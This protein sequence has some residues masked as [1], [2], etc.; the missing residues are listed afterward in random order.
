MRI[1]GKRLM[2]ANLLQGIVSVVVGLNT[3]ATF[4]LAFMV[5]VYKGDLDRWRKGV[6]EVSVEV[7]AQ[8]GSMQEHDVR[9]AKLDSQMVRQEALIKLLGKRTHD[10]RNILQAA[11]LVKDFSKL[12]SFDEPV[13]EG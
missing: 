7:K 10:L 12:A 1:F 11:Q 8:I 6:D 13:S 9:Q 3:I 4:S 2:D 5:G